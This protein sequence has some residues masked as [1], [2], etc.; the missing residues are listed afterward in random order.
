MTVDWFLNE[1]P[2]GLPELRDPVP[3]SEMELYLTNNYTN[4]YSSVPEPM[5][6]GQQDGQNNFLQY[7]MSGGSGDNSNNTT[8]SDIVALNSPNNVPSPSTATNSP[9]NTPVPQP[10]Q[11]VAPQQRKSPD[12]VNECRWIDQVTRQPCGLKFSEVSSLGQHITSHHVKDTPFLCWWENCKNVNHPFSRKYKL[13]Y[14]IRTHTK[15]KPHKCT[16]CSKQFTRLESYNSHRKTHMKQNSSNPSS[17]ANGIQPGGMT[18]SVLHSLHQQ[19]PMNVIM[20]SS[21]V[22]GGQMLQNGQLMGP[23]T[24]MTQPNNFAASK[25]P[26]TTQPNSAPISSSSPMPPN[27]PNSGPSLG[28]PSATIKTEVSSQEEAGGMLNNMSPST[29]FSQSQYQYPPPS[30]TPITR[31]PSVTPCETQTTTLGHSPAQT[32]NMTV[33]PHMGPMPHTMLHHSHPGAQGNPRFGH[34]M[35][36]QKMLAN[37]QQQMQAGY[38]MMHP[39]MHLV[40]QPNMG[41]PIKPYPGPVQQQQ[42]K[43]KSSPQMRNG[44][45]HSQPNSPANN[46]MSPHIKTSPSIKTSASP[47]NLMG[48]PKMSSTAPNSQKLQQQTDINNSTPATS[49]SQVPHPTNQMSHPTNH[50]PPGPPNTISHPSGQMHLPTEQLSHPTNQMSHPSPQMSHPS[51]QMSH[52]SNQISHPSIQMSHPSAQMSHPTSQMSHPSPQMS[53]PSTQMSHPSA[54]MSHPSNHLQHAQMPGSDSRMM[55]MRGPPHMAHPGVPPPGH[56]MPGMMGQAP[57]MYMNMMSARP[58]TPAS[59]N[60]STTQQKGKNNVSVI[61]PI[62]NK[63][64]ANR[65]ALRK[66]IK[67]TTCG[68][69]V[70][71]IDKAMDEALEGPSEP[72]PDPR[73]SGQSLASYPAQY[74]VMPGYNDQFKRM[75]YDPAYQDQL[76][77]QQYYLVPMQQQQQQA[78][79][80]QAQQAQAQ[81]QQAQQQRPPLYPSPQPNLMMPHMG[82]GPAP[83]LGPGHGMG[84][85][86]T[87][88]SHTPPPSQHVMMGS[89]SNMYPS[90]HESDVLGT[91]EPNFTALLTDPSMDL[92]DWSWDPNNISKT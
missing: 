21:V 34:Q 44:Q 41:Q 67:G 62:C 81:Q 82:P 90:N 77:R 50:A 83:H 17:P 8:P 89:Q 20:S 73:M 91:S 23:I 19:P 80:Q 78:Q 53:H 58:P 9:R 43:A 48:S 45:S 79:Q 61:C 37:Q 28:D 47:S 24:I 38:N 14:H 59:S 15:E 27:L 10:P 42:V 76:A 70:T 85:A 71:D 64:Y 56:M 25:S 5:F 60:R 35:L 4:T 92:F 49:S 3:S 22:P 33:S 86:P 88:M 68:K 65:K 57:P 6:P 87:H 1:T 11:N 16:E 12:E 32:P 13:I 69:S 2:P 31:P 72:G 29:V 84:A 66:H 51:N 7:L 74:G 26:P 63:I 18:S 39:N 55:G 52:P 75:R 40:M 36:R 30:V 46:S 54:Q